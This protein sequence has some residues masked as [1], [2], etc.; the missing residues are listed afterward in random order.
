MPPVLNTAV[1][2]KAFKAPCLCPSASVD[3]CAHACVRV[4]ACTRVYASVCECACV[5]ASVRAGMRVRT[6][7]RLRASACVCV[8]LRACA[9]VCVR[10]P[11]S[12][13]E[14]VAATL[15]HFTVQRRM[16]ECARA[17]VCACRRAYVRSHACVD[18]ACMG[19][20]AHARACVRWSPRVT[21]G[22]MRA[23]AT[24]RSRDHTAASR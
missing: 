13:S 11:E 21:P 6:C 10:V 12:A 8:R 3:A 19:A 16:C 5:C 22:P 7:V 15:V 4:H 2:F 23:T 24:S 18:H 1:D 17:G 14:V 9:C 20:R